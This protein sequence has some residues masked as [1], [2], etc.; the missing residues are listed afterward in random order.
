MAETAARV[1]A[2]R[3]TTYVLMGEPRSAKGLRRFGVSLPERLLEGCRAWTCASSPTARSSPETA[4][5]LAPRNPGGAD[6]GGADRGG[7]PA[8]RRG[9]R[10]STSG[11]RR[12]LFPFI[13]DNVS[14][15][16]LKAVLRLARVEDATLVPVYIATVPLHLA[17][18]AP[19][20]ASAGRP[21]LCSRRSSSR[22]PAPAWRWTAGSRPAARRATRSSSWS[23]PSGSTV[24]FPRRRA[25]Q[26]RLSPEDIAW[27]LES[28]PGRSWCC[29]PLR[30]PQRS[31]RL[32]ANA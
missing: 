10:G 5:D 2:T 15:S 30:A 27:L 21:C 1:A 12:I 8:R 6:R 17:L 4:N 23:T 9:H 20:P 29:G 16:A 24:S 28:A 32:A 3:G 11:A 13:G 31:R 19:I 7:L 22:P 26:R 25:R 14:E 18:E